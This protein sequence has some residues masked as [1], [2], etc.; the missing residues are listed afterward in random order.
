L[1]S[2]VRSQAEQEQRQLLKERDRETKKATSK[3]ESTRDAVA[4]RRDSELADARAATERTVREATAMREE[5]L[6]QAQEKYPPLLE[7]IQTTHRT[8]L[9][10]VQRRFDAAKTDNEAEYQRSWQELSAR[11]YDGIN[12]L[13][14]EVAQFNQDA[15]RLFPNWSSDEWRNWAPARTAPPSIRFGELTIDIQS[16]PDGVS[17]E[18]ALNQGVPPQWKFPA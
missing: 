13:V 5:T 14:E 7:R 11:W 10:E 3:F 16:V 9:D 4:K 18:A 17:N 12:R 6:R 1:T 2:T 15:Q 8:S